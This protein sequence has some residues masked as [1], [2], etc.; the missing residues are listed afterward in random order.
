M[1][2]FERRVRNVHVRRSV[3]LN[4]NAVGRSAL[5]VNLSM[6]YTSC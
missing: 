2:S 1:H 6:F 3:Q 5:R 4:P